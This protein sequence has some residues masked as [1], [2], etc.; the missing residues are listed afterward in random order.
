MKSG[1]GIMENVYSKYTPLVR[2][3]MTLVAWPVLVLKRPLLGP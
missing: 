2:I 3:T 1:N